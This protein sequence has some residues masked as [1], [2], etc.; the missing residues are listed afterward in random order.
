MWLLWLA[1]A[2]F[3]NCNRVGE[4][5]RRC[6]YRCSDSQAAGQV[7]WPKKRKE[8]AVY[9]WPGRKGRI[10]VVPSISD[11]NPSSPCPSLSRR[12]TA[13][14]QQ[15][16]TE[17]DSL[18][19]WWRLLLG[20]QGFSPG[21]RKAGVMFAHC[22]QYSCSRGQLTTESPGWLP[23]PSPWEKGR[24]HRCKEEEPW[25]AGQVAEHKCGG[26]RHS[27]LLGGGLPGFCPLP[28]SLLK[29]LRC[30]S[31]PFTRLQWC[32]PCPV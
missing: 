24:G 15:V 9:I 2:F 23:G 7:L 29:T 12:D 16:G 1:Y 5:T 20:G 3:P 17:A 18:P 31:Q 21:Q 25:S 11:G 19:R 8:G 26:A 30:I 4:E 32:N 10:R 22:S 13:R 14:V 28:L 27:L 6:F